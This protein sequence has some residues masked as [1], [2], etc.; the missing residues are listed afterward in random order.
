MVSEALSAA[1]FL[2]CL[3]IWYLQGSRISNSLSQQEGQSR[4]GHGIKQARVLVGDGSDS[5]LGS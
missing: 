1:D 2:R 5:P 3:R 4:M